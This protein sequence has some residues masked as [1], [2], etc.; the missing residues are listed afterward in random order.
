MTG[1]AARLAAALVVCLLAGACTPEVKP[2]PADERDP[3][4]PWEGYNRYMHEFNMRVDSAI[5]RPT[6]R[7][8]VQVTPEPAQKGVSNF[9]SNL[10]QPVVALNQVLQ[11]KFEEAGETTSRF[12][13][14][15]TWGAGGLTDPASNGN[16]PRH[17]EDFGQTLAAWGWEESRYFVI[18]F[19]GPSTVRDTVG[20]GADSFVDAPYRLIIT[21]SESVAAYSLL[22]LNIIQMR[23]SFLPQEAA[24]EDL[25]DEYLFFRDAY[26]QRRD[27]LITDGEG[28]LPDYDSYLDDEDWDDWD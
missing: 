26:L 24:R 17:N 4:D 13:M 23:A 19:L 1:P 7:A 6:A 21:G 2:P 27:Y 18:P 16:I 9:F 5:L 25:Y 10:R 28:A 3:A 20:R 12:L 14:N 8:Y 15:S 11:G 22:A